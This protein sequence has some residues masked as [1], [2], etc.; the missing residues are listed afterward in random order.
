MSEDFSD[1]A[2]AIDLAEN[3]DPRAPVVLVLDASSSMAQTIPGETQT[4]LDAL[5]AG[6]DVLISELRRDPLAR[7][8]VELSVVSF[9]TEVTPA[10]P[11]LG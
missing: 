5:N 3:P 6:L 11:F 9:G 8:R 1:I 2:G 10:T 7:R 4:A